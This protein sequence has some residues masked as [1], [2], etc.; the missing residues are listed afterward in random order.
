M[1]RE[2]ERMIS[3]ENGEVS[4]VHFEC[5]PEFSTAHLPVRATQRDLL[6]ILLDLISMVAAI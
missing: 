1:E 3:K 4:L 6:E 2:V 5:L